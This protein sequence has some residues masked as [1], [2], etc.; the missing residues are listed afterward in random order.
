M[1]QKCQ[2][3]VDTA[4]TRQE[5]STS[6][7]W[8]ALAQAQGHAVARTV[9]ACVELPNMRVLC[10]DVAFGVTEWLCARQMCA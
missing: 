7:S 8:S 6:S 10:T 2:F 9:K 1:I 4:G 3:W 5:A